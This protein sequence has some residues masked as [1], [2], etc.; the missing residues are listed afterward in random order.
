MNWPGDSSQEASFPSLWEPADFLIQFYV[1]RDFWNNLHALVRLPLF[2]RLLL[3]E[4]ISKRDLKRR[5]EPVRWSLLGQA[6]GTAEP[7]ETS[8]RNWRVGWERTHLDVKCHNIWQE[9][10]VCRK[11]EPTHTGVI[12]W[13]LSKGKLDN[14]VLEEAR[15]LLTLE[16]CAKIKKERQKQQL[17]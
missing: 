4:Q 3:R 14:T 6:C 16:Q 17:P 10:G 13:Q 1:L 8:Y 5:A 7:R 9:E 15:K 2:W 11:W 12:A